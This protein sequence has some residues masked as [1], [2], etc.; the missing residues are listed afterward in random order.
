M[1]P[2][3]ELRYEHEVLRAQLALLEEWVPYFCVTPL[4]L[5][6]LV[7]SLADHLRVHT[8]HEERRV[9]ALRDGAQSLPRDLLDRLQTDHV[10]QRTRL[11][12]LH[13]LVSRDSAQ[14]QEPLL[15]QAG[16]FIRD[17]REHLAAEEAQ[18][19]PLIDRLGGCGT[20]PSAAE[21]E[22]VELGL[23]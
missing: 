3:D 17:M 5:R 6:R 14:A 16:G 4:S 10:N 7:L 9:A 18:V 21:A 20:P 13:D 15:T 12:V 2:S 23:A 22:L 1:K 11:A 8:E 19:F